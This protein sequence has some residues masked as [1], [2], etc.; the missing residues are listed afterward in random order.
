M[1]DLISV[2]KI[3][4][5][6]FEEQD[7]QFCFIGGIA[8]QFWDEQ[9]LTKTIDLALLPGFDYDEL[10]GYN[11]DESL[12]N[13]AL[14]KFAGRIEDVKEFALSNRVILL[15][16]ESGIGFDVWL[17]HS[18]FAHSM[19]ERAK[20]KVYLPNL[21]LKICTPEDFIVKAL[22]DKDEYVSVIETVLTKE[23]SIKF[24]YI[25]EQLSYLGFKDA[26]VISERLRVMQNSRKCPN[27][28]RDITR[29][30]FDDHI[31]TNCGDY[32][33][34]KHKESSSDKFVKADFLQP[35]LD[36]TINIGYPVR[37]AGKYGTHPGHDGF[38]DESN[39]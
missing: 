35:N 7:W 10:T 6:F 8:L 37:E 36:A 30:T 29:E 22:A 28:D 19:I 3:I 18:D 21:S 1:T 24:S 38:D 12:I 9:R 39:A 16:T 5:E 23:K 14:E 25:C 11:D 26:D 34:D 13:T 27:C 20:Y 17:G 15:Q 33:Q 2:A 31:R 32:Y 4:Q